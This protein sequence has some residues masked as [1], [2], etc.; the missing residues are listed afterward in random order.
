MDVHLEDFPGLKEAGW[1]HGD[2]L[3]VGPFEPSA[4][5][6][7]HV[8]SGVAF[9]RCPMVL[10]L[11]QLGSPCYPGVAIVDECQDAWY[12]GAGDGQA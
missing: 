8:V 9:E 2:A 10:P 6:R 3:D 12:L 4:P 7:N 1:Q 5:A 11:R